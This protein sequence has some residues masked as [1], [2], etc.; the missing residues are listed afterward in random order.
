MNPFGLNPRCAVPK[1]LDSITCIGEEDI[2][3]SSSPGAREIEKI[4][5]M[6]EQLY[7]SGSEHLYHGG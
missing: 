1:D 2:D 5:E 4:W 7:R 3:E 6:T